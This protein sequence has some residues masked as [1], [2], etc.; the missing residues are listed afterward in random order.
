MNIQLGSYTCPSVRETK[1]AGIWLPRKGSYK[2]WISGTRRAASTL[3]TFWTFASV[4]IGH[5]IQCFF[6]LYMQWTSNSLRI[7]IDSSK[8][9]ASCCSRTR[10]QPLVYSIKYHG[11]GSVL[12]TS[13][14]LIVVFRAFFLFV[15]ISNNQYWCFFFKQMNI[16]DSLTLFRR[17]TVAKFKFQTQMSMVN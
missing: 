1:H 15:K 16:L 14:V 7:Y 6:E 17:A 5:I 10:T 12:Q 2:G 3:S 4:A 11:V 13:I 9:Y 8:G